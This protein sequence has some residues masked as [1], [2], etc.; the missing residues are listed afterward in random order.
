M[1]N[2]LINRG[3]DLDNVKTGIDLQKHFHPLMYK[4]VKVF[5]ESVAR[6]YVGCEALLYEFGHDL[7]QERVRILRL[8]DVAILNYAT[9]ASI[10]RANRADC[11][12]Q[13]VGNLYNLLSGCVSSR[14]RF[15]VKHLVIDMT[16]SSV[17]SFE[18]YFQK[19][20]TVMLKDKR[21]FPEHPLTRFF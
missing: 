8:A 21:Y 19:L 15:L 12:E 20:A 18:P 11:L 1:M 3:I 10:T 9:M 2:T 13:P 17:D 16:Q 14:H 7:P 6:Q 5:D 4:N